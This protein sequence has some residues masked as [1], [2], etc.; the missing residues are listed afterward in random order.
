MKSSHLPIIEAAGCGACSRR[1]L[2][3][4]LGIAAV[5]A[6]IFDASC[7]QQGSSLSTATT[8]TCGT[9]HCID[10]GDAANQELATVGGAMLIDS[11]RDTIMVIRASDT[12]VFA[13]SAIC[14]H[15]GCAM[16]YN[17][18]QRVLDCGC[19]G[20]QFSTT[21]TVLRGP[22]NRAVHAYT[23]TL[24]NNMITVDG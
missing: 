5:G 10:L 19:H 14:T 16:D 15:A 4:G 23:A 11:A 24:A 21:G 7:Q 17:A 2:L 3:R 13:L 1:T 9:G 12:Q 22:A 20:S 18:A 6:L 8:S